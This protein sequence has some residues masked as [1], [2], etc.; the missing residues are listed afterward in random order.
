MIK[1]G[2]KFDGNLFEMER[3][4]NVFVYEVF[5]SG[6]IGEGALYIVGMVKYCLFV[7]DVMFIF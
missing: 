6:L 1:Y 3:K 4:L 7:L 5:D 2:L